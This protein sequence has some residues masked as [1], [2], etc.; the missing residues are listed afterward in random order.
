METVMWVLFALKIAN[1]GQFSWWI[2]IGMF[3]VKIIYEL[4]TLHVT[5]KNPTKGW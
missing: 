5:D 4:V 1:V 3:I 2:P